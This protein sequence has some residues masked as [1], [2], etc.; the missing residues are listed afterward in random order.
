LFLATGNGPF[1]PGVGDYGDS[2]LKLSPGLQVL[3]YFTPFDQ[4]NASDTDTDLG[5]GGPMILDLADSSA[6]G[7]KIDHLA[8]AI[9]KSVCSS[10]AADEGLSDD[11]AAVINAKSFAEAT[12]QSAKIDHVAI[13]IK[14]GVCSCVAA[15]QGTAHDLSAIIYARSV[16]GATA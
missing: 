16:A 15:D 14:E 8:I 3:D 5:S 12:A 4:Q 6:D 11:L 9:E 13:G 1:D 10:V 7:A 2:V